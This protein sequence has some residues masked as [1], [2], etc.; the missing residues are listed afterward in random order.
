MCVVSCPRSRQPPGVLEHFSVFGGL[1]SGHV[2]A[3]HTTRIPFVYAGGVNDVWI[4]VGWWYV[5][6]YVRMD[7]MNCQARWRGVWWRNVMRFGA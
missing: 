7:S 6:T 4:S 1:S 5:S 3:R 2:R